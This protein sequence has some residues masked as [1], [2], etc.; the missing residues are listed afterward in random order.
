MFTF[1]WPFFSVYSS[2]FSR[3]YFH[4]RNPRQFLIIFSFI[5]SAR[6]RLTYI[7]AVNYAR[8]FLPTFIS[9]LS[10]FSLFVW[11]HF[12]HLR[13][14]WICSLCAK[15]PEISMKT[16]FSFFEIIII[17][18]A[19]A[20]LVSIAPLKCDLGMGLNIHMRALHSRLYSIFDF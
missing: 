3:V 11:K 4:S 20:F 18:F 17:P 7:H 16:N 12:A 6:K 14:F 1:F 19:A 8:L 5:Y 15:K 9:L 13:K 10:C 2:S